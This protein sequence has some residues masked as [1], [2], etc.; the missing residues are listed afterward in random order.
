MN[1][2]II[3]KDREKTHVHPARL[4]IRT[5]NAEL[6]VEPLLRNAL[7]SG[8]DSF[9]V[10]GMQR[11]TPEEEVLVEQ[12]WRLP[13]NT[14]ICRADIEESPRSLATIPL[15]DKEHRIDMLGELA[16]LL[17]ALVQ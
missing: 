1:H 6:F 9:T 5:Y 17:F 8:N 10:L 12:L 13:P 16:E 15:G 14:L 4:A 7:Q 11:F 3:I 2:A